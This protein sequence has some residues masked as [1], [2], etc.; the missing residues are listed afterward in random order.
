LPAKKLYTNSPFSSKI[1]NKFVFVKVWGV[2]NPI[3][4]IFLLFISLIT[5]FENI[6]VLFLL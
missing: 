3:K 6:E 1:E 2:I 4:P 5:Y